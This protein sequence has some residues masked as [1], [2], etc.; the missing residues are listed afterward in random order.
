[1]SINV[2]L[3]ILIIIFLFYFSQEGLVGG[4]ALDVE[5]YN[6]FAELYEG[7]YRPEVMEIQK[8][9]RNPI[10]I[11][12][13][14]SDLENI[15]KARTEESKKILEND[16]KDLKILLLKYGQAMEA[17]EAQ[18]L[19]KKENEEFA[20]KILTLR[21]KTGDSLQN[22]IEKRNKYIEMQS[23]WL[24]KIKPLYDNFAVKISKSDLEEI[25][26]I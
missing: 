23:L 1:M 6:A 15:E 2:V 13:V 24:T 10:I 20:E 7:K 4:L 14:Y 21:K 8:Y 19:I 17:S 26:T 16:K 9:I 3:L 5:K 11:S 25:N 12:E 22:I 18:N